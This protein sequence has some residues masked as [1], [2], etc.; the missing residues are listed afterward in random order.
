MGGGI[1]PDRP[2]RAS[3]P[4]SLRNPLGLAWL[5]TVGGLAA[6]LSLGSQTGDMR[7]VGR[8]L[9]AAVVQIPAVWVVLGIVAA[10]FGIVPRL[11]TAAWALLAGFLLLGEFGPLLRLPNGLI[12]LSPYAHMPKLPGG[13]W[14]V[15]PVAFSVLIAAALVTFGVATF[16]RR[17]VD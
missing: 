14:T 2:G 5:L 16:S 12:D 10:L 4:T 17:D 7:Q 9:A 3:A 8:L 13:V 15:A 11:V 6:G 1:L